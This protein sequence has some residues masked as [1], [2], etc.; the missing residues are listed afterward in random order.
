MFAL[1]AWHSFLPTLAED[2]LD[3][4]QYFG[5]QG[6][7]DVQL[8]SEWD[9]GNNL[10]MEWHVLPDFAHETA[11]DVVRHHHTLAHHKLLATLMCS[12]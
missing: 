5:P 12:A 10:E 9:A 4:E 2:Q 3:H 1:M 6:T 7:V 8:E 11:E